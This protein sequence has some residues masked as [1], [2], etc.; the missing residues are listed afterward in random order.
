VLGPLVLARG[1]PNS[2]AAWS[3]LLRALARG[4][5]VMLTVGAPA[6]VNP[7]TLAAPV[8]LSWF[9]AFA[10]AV[11]ALR[12]R[13]PAAPAAPA[14][15]GFVAALA[16]VAGR[17]APDFW[18]AP[19]LAGLLLLL[20][21]VRASDAGRH[22][23]KPRAGVSRWAWANLLIGMP[24]LVVAL[25]A[26]TALAVTYPGALGP[27]RADPRALIDQQLIIQSMVTPLSTIK[28]QLRTAPAVTL[29]TLD[30]HG[31]AVPGG[32]VRIATLDD[33]DG[34]IWSTRNAYHLVSTE[35]TRDASLT[36]PVD[37]RLDVT[38]DGLPGPFL[39]VVGIPITM[40]TQGA[41]RTI[42]Y[43]PASSNLV[44]AE[45][46]PGGLRYRL[47][48]L[49][50]TDRLDDTAVP[51][52]TDRIDL[53]AGL[54]EIIQDAAVRATRNQTTAV[55]KL[56]AIE[57]FL[58]SLPYDLDAAPGHS[59]AVIARMLQP[60][61]G[62][63]D[64]GFAEQ[65][66]AAFALMARALGYR[67]RV[68]VGYRLPSTADRPMVVTTREAYAWP[69]VEF[70]GLGWVRFDPTDSS[71]EGDSSA[72]SDNAQQEQH[73]SPAPSAPPATAAQPTT[74]QSAGHRLVALVALIVAVTTVLIAT[75]VVI[76]ALVI[77]AEKARRRYVR[78][79]APDPARRVLGAWHDA[80]DRL[81]ERGLPCPTSM[82]AE[83]VAVEAAMNV[84]ASSAPLRALAPIVTQASFAQAGATWADAD[85]AWIVEAGHI[86]R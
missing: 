75:L 9:A 67:A 58:R 25:G 73:P 77:A 65:H 83:E 24:M 85:H 74:A 33:F 2:V 34:A 54:P 29:F 19:A 44:D 53:P 46:S 57:A 40:S 84:P 1:L 7:H 10:T 30:T 56:R 26:G 39:P 71:R 76:A 47:T 15:L 62:S 43:D 12:I 51:L 37:V 55:A 41:A 3:G 81:V 16:L 68:A 79:R 8:T 21:L 11:M 4:F 86:D 17:P 14:L 52:M 28:A 18:I 60:R 50:S 32:F 48:C 22:A 35:L 45:P 63:D 36:H 72:S 31:Q 59:Y 49:V 70:E 78:R 38:V 13:A 82:T 66:A 6:P 5:G 23:G 61:Q 69:E 64:S 20:T 80:V 27:H 42:G